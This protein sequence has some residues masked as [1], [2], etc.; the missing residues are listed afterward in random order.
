MSYCTRICFVTRTFEQLK[1]RFHYPL[2]SQFLLSLLG[3]NANIHQEYNYCNRD[4]NIG[5]T[6]TNSTTVP[7]ALICSGPFQ[8]FKVTILS[9]TRARIFIPWA[10]I[11]SGP[12]Q[13]FKV[14]IL[15]SIGARVFI[16]RALIR[17]GP[18]QQFYMTI[19]SSI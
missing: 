2:K 13:H 10:L 9:S 18:F 1:N 14:A 5:F 11:C 7:W 17:P 19:L 8:Q 6:I 3:A 4:F 15:S 12:F 16:P